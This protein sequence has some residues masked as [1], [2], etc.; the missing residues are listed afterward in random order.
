LI[1]D[2]ATL[3][4][5]IEQ[6]RRYRPATLKALPAYLYVLALHFLDSGCGP[7][8]VARGISPM[9]GSLSPY[10]KRTIQEAFQCEVHEDYGSAELGAIAAECGSQ[11][12]LHPFSG[13][14]HVEVIRDGAPVPPGETGHIVITDLFSYAMPFIRYDIGDVGVLLNGRCPC[15]ITANRLQVQG[16]SRDCVVNDSGRLVT[17]DEITDRVLALPGVLGFQLTVNK[18]GQT[19]LKVVPRKGRSP[20]LSDA[21]DAVADAIGQDLQIRVRHAPTIAPEASGKFRFV[22]NLGWRMECRV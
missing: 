20:N 3:D 19:D 6:M 9:G 16:R 10:M 17:P 22:R 1:Q 8:R 4:E 12:G 13:L 2:A 11:S 14:F 7:P 18:D 15:G 5:Y 21:A